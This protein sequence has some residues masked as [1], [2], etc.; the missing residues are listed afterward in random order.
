MSTFTLPLATAMEAFSSVAPFRANKADRDNSPILGTVQLTSP[1]GAFWNAPKDELVANENGEP[2]DLTPA[3]AG[4]FPR[5][6]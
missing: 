6:E 1:T 3:P 5:Y 2:W 4:V